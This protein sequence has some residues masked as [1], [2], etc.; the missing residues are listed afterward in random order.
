LQKAEHQIQENRTNA[1]VAN[2]P[3]YGFGF[4]L[5]DAKGVHQHFS[6]TNLLFGALE[7]LGHGHF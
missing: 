3:A 7:E 1:C 6:D 5:V 4:G 2:G